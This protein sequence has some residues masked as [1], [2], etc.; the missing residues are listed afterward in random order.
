MGGGGGEVH[1]EIHYVPL[2]GRGTYIAK[3]FSRSSTVVAT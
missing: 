2:G 3:S 1:N